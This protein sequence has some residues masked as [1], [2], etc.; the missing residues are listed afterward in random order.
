MIDRRSFIAAAAGWLVAAPQAARPQ[1]VRSLRV[2]WLSTGPH[3]FIEAFRQGLRDYG[4][5]EGKNLVIDQRYAE[6]APE[7]LSDL[8]AEL[9]ELRVDVNRS[10]VRVRTSDSRIPRCSGS[11]VRVSPLVKAPAERA[12]QMLRNVGSR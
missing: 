11:G 3:P 2:G 7:R 12:A 9:V 10:S 6:G 8:A 5:I 4:W 1:P